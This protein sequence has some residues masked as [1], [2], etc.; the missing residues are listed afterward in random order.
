[1]RIFS[2]ALSLI[3]TNTDVIIKFEL[4]GGYGL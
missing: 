4:G 3:R 1:M 2:V